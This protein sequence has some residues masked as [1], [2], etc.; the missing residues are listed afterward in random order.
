MGA[1]TKTATT[2]QSYYDVLQVCSRADP[3]VIHAAFRALMKR[4]H[5]DQGGSHKVA[6]AITEAYRILSDPL[7][8]KKYDRERTLVNRVGKVVGDYR[9]LEFIAEGGF[10]KTYK[11]VH[12]M[13]DEPVCI[14]H[15]S[16][17]SPTDEL[18]LIE[19]TKAVWNLRHFGIPVMQNLLRMDDG[20]LALVMSYIPGPTLEQIV[21]KVGRL[22]P[23]HVSWIVE[24]AL[25]VLMYLHHQG[26]VHGDIKPQNIIVQPESHNIVLV[27][28][29]LAAVKPSAAS[30]NKG[31]TPM[32]ASPEQERG[33]VLVPESDFYSLG[34]TMLFA[35]SGNP[36]ATLRKDV[37][38][39][40]PEPIKEFI[41]RIILR[42]VLARPNWK[43][44]NLF[45]TIKK[46]REKAFGRTRSSMKPIP[47]L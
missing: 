20:S 29:G 7:E 30:G 14:K 46:V 19:E 34:M 37:P 32:Y 28:F 12:I 45:E 11:G 9:I 4:C 18:F 33:E 23:E 17:V 40:V 41:R 8:R 15:C 5:P 47:G 25:N 27:D 31:F 16:N 24:R 44:E 36:D 26:V 22:D 38:A 10:G 35:L 13:A 3:D 39:D 1:K 6:A 21:K 42:D 43:T 2:E